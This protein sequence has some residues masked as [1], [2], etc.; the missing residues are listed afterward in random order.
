MA[1]TDSIPVPRKNAAF[2]L[3]FAIRDTSGALVA[4]WTGQDSE[5]SKD[6]GSFADCTNEATEIGTSGVGYI[7]LTSTEMNA[8]SVV[9]KLTVTNSNAI[10]MVISLYPEESGDYRVA[11]TQK[12]DINTIKTQAVTCAAGVSVPGSIASPTNI[13]AGTITT[14]TNLTNAPTSGDLTATMKASITAAVPSAA[15]ISTQV[16]ADLITDHGSGS[17]VAITGYATAVELAKVIKTGEEF[18]ATDGTVTKDV[19]FTRI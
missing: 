17:W 19:T 4:S 11:D 3:Y 2:R 16:R 15:S 5:V 9:Y 8:D 1:A 13:T 14:V 18:T 10:S 6:G 7:D 12:V